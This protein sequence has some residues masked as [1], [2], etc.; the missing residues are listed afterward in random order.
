MDECPMCMQQSRSDARARLGHRVV[1]HVC[2]DYIKSNP[3]AL[4]LRQMTLKELS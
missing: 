1:C 2:E 3:L 4:G